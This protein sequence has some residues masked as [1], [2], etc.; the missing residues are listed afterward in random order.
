[1]KIA[2]ILWHGLRLCLCTCSAIYQ[3][4][5]ESLLEKL[6]EHFSDIEYALPFFVINKVMKSAFTK[7]IKL[8]LTM[9]RSMCTGIK[10][11]KRWKWR[12][13]RNI[14]KLANKRSIECTNWNLSFLIFSLINL[15]NLYNNLFFPCKLQLYMFYSLK[16]MLRRFF[17]TH[18]M[19]KRYSE[20]YSWLSTVNSKFYVVLSH[21]CDTT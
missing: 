12:K 14:A 16:L 17:W 10:Q 6:S 9:V 4:L 3:V 2:L 11:E 13:R 1:M 5:D 15:Y 20:C 7:G 18:I 19:L 21:E 8:I